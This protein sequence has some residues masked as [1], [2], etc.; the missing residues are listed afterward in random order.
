LKANP[1]KVDWWHISA[2][3]NAFEL[4]EAYWCS[5]DRRVRGGKWWWFRKSKK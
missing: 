3:P 1:D 5:N 2:N 4:S